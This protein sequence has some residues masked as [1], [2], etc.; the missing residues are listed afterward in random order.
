MCRY[1]KSQ[2][3][4]VNG[5]SGAGKTETTKIAMR[6]L[7][8]LAGWACHRPIQTLNRQGGAQRLP[9]PSILSS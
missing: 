9:N 4:I 8:G 6:Y 2:S 7:A 1:G 3:I 5:E